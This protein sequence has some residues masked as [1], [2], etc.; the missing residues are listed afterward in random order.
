MINWTEKDNQKHSELAFERALELIDLTV[1]DNKN[2][3]RLGE[4]LRMREFLVGWY[5]D[6]ADSIFDKNAWLKYFESYNYYARLE[7]GSV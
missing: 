5:I 4:I 6:R 2:C 1:L 3:S 7:S